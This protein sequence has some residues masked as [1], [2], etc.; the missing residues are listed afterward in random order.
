MSNK[1]NDSKALSD[2]EI[3]ERQDTIVSKML[4]TP[5]F[6]HRIKTNGGRIGRPIGT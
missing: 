1:V 2:K 4:R 6:N 5:P 3:S